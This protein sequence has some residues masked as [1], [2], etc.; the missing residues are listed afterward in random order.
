[1]QTQKEITLEEYV[2]NDA[3]LVMFT[4]GR[5][6]TLAACS[7]MLK[8]IPVHL[9]TANSGCSL[10]RDVLEV[11]VR[12]MRSRFG[13]L[14]LK[15]VKQDISGSFRSL[16]IADLEQDILT[17]RKN[18]VL[19]GEKIAIHCHVVDYCK[20]NDITI[21][22]DGI[23]V[24]PK[25]FPEQRSVARDY[26]VEFMKGYGITYESPIYNWAQ[27]SDDVKYKLLQLGLS[28]KSLEGLSVFADSFTTPSDEVVL[29][30]LRDKERKAVDIIDFLQG[31]KV[32]SFT[33]LGASG[34]AKRSSL[35]KSFTK[36]FLESRPV[37]RIILRTCFQKSE[38]S[39]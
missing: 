4:G 18:L 29:Q 28:T 31:S 12:E 23:A 1:M 16:A 9:Y 39:C 3:Q 30:Y 20:R 17:Y 26:F 13:G 19:L 2:G 38:R 11:R 10:H 27:S 14:I 35:N 33:S 21:V 15:H 36:S 34:Y 6:S 5:D 8:G 22:N 24:Y 25:E 7:L 32:N 37:E